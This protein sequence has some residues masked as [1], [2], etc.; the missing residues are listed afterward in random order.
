MGEGW[1]SS[2]CYTLRG[3]NEFMRITGASRGVATS[4]GARRRKTNAAH[5]LREGTTHALGTLTVDLRSEVARGDVG[6]QAAIATR[7]SLVKRAVISIG[8]HAANLWVFEI[9]KLPRKVAVVV[10]NIAITPTRVVCRAPLT[11][12]GAKRSA[13]R[14]E[15]NATVNT[16]VI[17]ERA[18]LQPPPQQRLR[19]RVVR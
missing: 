6:L 18:T 7:E 14:R 2:I 9:L 4:A 3:S 17:D 15:S 1:P 5:C 11:R 16:L 13:G 12:S 10:D 8:I 19:H